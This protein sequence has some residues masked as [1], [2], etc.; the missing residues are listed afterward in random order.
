M[1][2]YGM[3]ID[4]AKCNG[5]YNC[6]IACKDEHCGNDYPP[7][8]VAQPMLGHFWI[9]II[10]RERGVFPKIKVAYIPVMCMHCKDAHC[11]QL[12]GDGE[13][14]QRSDGLVIIDPERASGKR[15]IVDSCP[16]RV[17]YWN[18][19]KGIPQKCTFCAHLLDQGW[20][21]PRCAEACPTGAMVFGDLDDPESDVSR[22][23]TSA[24]VEAIH[25]EFGLNEK[26]L[27]IGLPKR[28][29]SGTVILE[30]KDDGY[31]E[32]ARVTL[33]GEGCEMTARTDNYGDFEFEGIEADKEYSVRIEYPGY[34]QETIIVKTKKDVYLGEIILRR[35]RGNIQ[36]VG[37]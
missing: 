28:F 22:L 1:T 29:I 27:Y 31:G 18:E 32:N 3:V 2:Q 5:C 30:D 6:F 25:P 7:Y 34:V 36:E 37:T 23:I 24:K 12:S 9:K 13:V 35:D 4:L 14:Y 33:I 17:I 15:G 16:Y 21:E 19:E 8:S 10:E 20:K 26:V 11:V